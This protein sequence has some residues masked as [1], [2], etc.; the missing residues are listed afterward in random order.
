MTDDG[1]DELSA[2]L[3]YNKIL[4]SW[5]VAFGVG[6]PALFLINA[7]ISKILADKGELRYVC[8]ISE[9]QRLS[10]IRRVNQQDQ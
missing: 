5:F 9:W 7:Q 1:K 6:G 3:E 4:R 10:G 2:Y 8:L